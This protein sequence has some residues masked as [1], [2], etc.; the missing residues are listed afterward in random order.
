MK[1]FLS[2]VILCALPLLHGCSNMSF[3]ALSDDDSCGAH[4]FLDLTGASSDGLPAAPFLEVSCT[5]TL[6]LVET[7]ALPNFEYAQVTP[8]VIKEADLYY[9]IPPHHH[10]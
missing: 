7:N 5:E 9:E 1:R 4:H 2:P 6:L 8:N 3:T 10:L